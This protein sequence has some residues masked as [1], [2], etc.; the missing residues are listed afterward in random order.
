MK[1]ILYISNRGT[2]LG[3]GEISLLGLVTNLD[4]KRFSPLV[5][6]PEKG[7]YA[8]ALREAGVP[9][10]VTDLP[11]VRTI[12]LDLVFRSV[13][14]LARLVRERNIEIIHANGSRTMLLGGVAGLLAGVPRVWH[15]RV[16]DKSDRILD[17]ILFALA[18]R[19]IV[20]S[21]AVRDRLSWTEKREK[22][23]LIP[24]GVDVDRFHPRNVQYR[25]SMRTELGIDPLSP[26]VCTM[27]R[28]APL[29][30]VDVFIRAA[31]GIASAVPKA[32]FLVCGREAPD[33]TG[34][35]V[36]LENLAR[37]L[38]VGEK[39]IFAGFRTDPHKV[40]ASAD[41]LVLASSEEAFGRVLIEAMA[42]GLPVLGTAT[43]GIPDVIEDGKT[44]YL[45]D[46]GDHETLSRLAIRILQDKTLAGTL[47]RNGR[48]RVEEAFSITA[49]VKRI[50][51][52][53]EEMP[54]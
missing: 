6:L 5:A 48:H 54:R 37:D 44:G 36:E 16:A 49:H 22:I 38:G 39:V 50:Q 13:L 15:L 20:I 3:G 8:D 23:H 42:T 53:Y 43:G 34:H 40:L 41:L 35:R 12:R 51:S 27:C 52:L 19:V 29:K 21:S 46:I 4:L 30:Q 11:T 9:F 10:I 31:A 18:G 45:F 47:G 2:I 7:D 1:Q 28:L 33:S 25:D 14:R 32:K 17:R 24:N 26:V